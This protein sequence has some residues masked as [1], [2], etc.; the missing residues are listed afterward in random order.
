MDG[1]SEGRGVI[2]RDGKENNDRQ[3]LMDKDKE[4]E[5]NRCKKKKKETRQRDIGRDGER[6]IKRERVESVQPMLPWK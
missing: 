3:S 1:W 4:R 2:K 6:Q 5:M